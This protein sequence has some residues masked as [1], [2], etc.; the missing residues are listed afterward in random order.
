M[1]REIVEKLEFTPVEAPDGTQAIIQAR[2][3]EP[4]LILLDIVM[5][6]KSGLETPQGSAP[7]PKI[8]RD[9]HH[10]A[11]SGSRGSRPSFS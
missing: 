7:G 4:V 8:G 1:V 2:Y 9:S 6:G 3:H 11:D 10:H 5:P